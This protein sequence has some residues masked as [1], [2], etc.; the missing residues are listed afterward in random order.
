MEVTLAMRTGGFPRKIFVDLD[1][2]FTKSA[3]FHDDLSVIFRMIL[4]E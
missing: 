4:D 2:L 3:D 1:F